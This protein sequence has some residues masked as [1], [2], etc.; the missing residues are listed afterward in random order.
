MAYLFDTTKFFKTGKP[1]TTGVPSCVE[2]RSLTRLKEEA[3]VHVWS[4]ANINFL[5]DKGLHWLS[6]HSWNLGMHKDF[7]KLYVTQ[8]LYP[9]V[10]Y[11]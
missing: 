7:V 4:D 2:A 10:T 8:I 6:E 5:P 3:Y 9:A 11:Q 1:S